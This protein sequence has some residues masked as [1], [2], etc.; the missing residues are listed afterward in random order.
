M[1][2]SVYKLVCLHLR[3]SILV[4]VGITWVHFIWD[5]IHTNHP[6][7]SNIRFKL[8]VMLIT[9]MFSDLLL[10][11]TLFLLVVFKYLNIDAIKKNFDFDLLIVL[12]CSLTLGKAFIDS[13]AAEMLSDQF[14][15]IVPRTNPKLVIASLF[16]LT[17]V[18]TSLITNVAA[19]SIAFP[20]AYALAHDLNLDGAAFYLTIAF[21]ASAAFLTPTAYQTNMMVYGPGG[22]KSFDFFKAGF[23]LLI[24]YSITSLLMIFWWYDV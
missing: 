20:L 5:V 15:N 19:V 4:T 24:I 9:V 2:S 17:V 3:L 16:F 6:S 12:A 22:Y 7:I 13:G 21:G 23:P 14:L 10:I 18:L 11:I 1:P 8:L